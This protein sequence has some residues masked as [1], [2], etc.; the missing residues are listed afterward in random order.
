MR[1]NVSFVT[2]TS[3][4]IEKGFRSCKRCKP[5]DVTD[6]NEEKQLRI[7]EQ[8]KELLLQDNGTD[9]GMGIKDIA[10]EVG[11][12][13]WHLHRVFKSRVGTTPDMWARQ[14]RKARSMAIARGVISGANE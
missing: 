4:A 13:H 3:E 8:M 11:V 7:V 12:S 9:K 2:T 10:Q 1:P 6:P 5:D 14:E